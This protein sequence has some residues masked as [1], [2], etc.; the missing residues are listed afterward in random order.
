MGGEEEG[1]EEEE[2]GWMRPAFVFCLS[3]GG[4]MADVRM[5][6]A[7][8]GWIPPFR[9]GPTLSPPPSPSSP[10]H[11]L[12][13][14]SVI[15]FHPVS[16]H[17]LIDLIIIY[18]CLFTDS[19]FTMKFIRMNQWIGSIIWIDVNNWLDMNSLAMLP[20][21]PPINSIPIIQWQRIDA[22]DF[23]APFLYFSSSSSSSASS[24]GVFG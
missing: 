13:P 14:S 23:I 6:S 3:V 20:D 11:F 12:P 7:G 22:M 15:H 2:D 21:S 24:C 4:F 5:H 1:E 10:S 9:A 18:Y 8:T 16:I 17:W 19:A